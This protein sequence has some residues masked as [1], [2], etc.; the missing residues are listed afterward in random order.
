MLIISP[1]EALKKT[2]TSVSFSESSKRIYDVL[3]I[4][5]LFN[6]KNRLREATYR[7]WHI[8]L[9]FNRNKLLLVN[10]LL[11]QL[12]CDHAYKFHWTYLNQKN[13]VPA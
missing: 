12:I 9:K 3:C 11:E 13:V 1:P 6:K 5:K 4:H 8:E 2:V 10:V 7:W